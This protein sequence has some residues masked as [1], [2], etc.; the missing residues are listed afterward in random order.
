MAA[1]LGEALGILGAMI[2]TPRLTPSQQDEILGSTGDNSIYQRVRLLTPQQRDVLDGL[3]SG[4][5]P[6]EACQRAGYKTSAPMKS[7]RDKVPDIMRRLQLDEEVLIVKYLKPLL[8]ANETQYFQKDGL[9]TDEREVEALGIR[10]QALDMAFKLTGAYATDED[11][12]DDKDI[13]VNIISV[14]AQQ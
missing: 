10:R 3:L 11:G 9:V 2:D 6:L 8:E 13:I 14:G 5:P 4:M 12:S 7:I 1:L